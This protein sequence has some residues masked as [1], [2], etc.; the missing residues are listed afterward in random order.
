MERRFYEVFF[1]TLLVKV[2]TIINVLLCAIKE[3]KDL[4]WEP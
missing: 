3:K 2:E 1:K 4:T